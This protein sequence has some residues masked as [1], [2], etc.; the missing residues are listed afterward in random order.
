MRYIAISNTTSA[1]TSFQSSACPPA[2][3][4]LPYPRSDDALHSFRMNLPLPPSFIT[5]NKAHGTLQTL[6]MSILNGTAT[7]LDQN[8][9]WLETSTLQWTVQVATYL[10]ICVDANRNVS[11]R[12][13]TGSSH[14]YPTTAFSRPSS[15]QYQNMY[16]SLCLMRASIMHSSWASLECYKMMWKQGICWASSFTM[17]TSRNR[18]PC[19]CLLW[20]MAQAS[21][22][23]GVSS[24]P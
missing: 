1:K 4:H 14:R 19:S 8:P 18:W 2:E 22:E 21:V 9:R 11:S 13:L 6:S 3:S 7:W 20:T 15:M 12:A 17:P 24:R 5:Q 23:D 16:L 10:Y